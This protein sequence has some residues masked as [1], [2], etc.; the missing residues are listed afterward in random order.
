LAQTK[1]MMT[2]TAFDWKQ[3]STSVSNNYCCLVRP[4]HG[5]ETQYHKK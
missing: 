5:W 1:K 2:A 3:H 4:K